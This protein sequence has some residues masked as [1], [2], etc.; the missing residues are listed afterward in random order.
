M[1]IVLASSSPSRRMILANAGVDPVIQPADVDEDALLASLQ[2]ASPADAVAALARAKAHAV[3]GQFHDDVVIGGDSML[4]LDGHL[5]GKPHT[6]EATVARWREQAGKVAQ[7]LTGH[8]IVHRGE[9]FV[10]TTSTTVHFAA[11][12]EA[13]ILAYA[14]SGEP[15]QC[16]GAFTLEALGG[17]FIDRIEGDPSSVIGLSLPT[18]RRALYRFGLDASAFWRS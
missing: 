6:E 2:D 1:R 7:L 3:A 8:C 17:W 9:E 15:W 12:S 14:A 5:Q 18:V 13:D 11:A 10:E 16:A 4:L